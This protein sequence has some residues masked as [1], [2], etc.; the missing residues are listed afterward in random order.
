MCGKAEMTQPDPPG[1]SQPELGEHLAPVRER[2]ASRVGRTAAGAG[3]PAFRRWRAA[4]GRQCRL[5]RWLRPAPGPGRPPAGG[6]RA[7]RLRQIWW[8]SVP[9]WSLGFL[10][11][12]PLL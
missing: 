1:G 9:V 4:A 8:A 3:R 7:G 12:A 5:G 2:P 10:S 11:F 6:S